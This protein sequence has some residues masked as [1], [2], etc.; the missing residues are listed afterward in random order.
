MPDSA[1]PSDNLSCTRGYPSDETDFGLAMNFILLPWQLL[2]LILVGWT[3]KQQRSIERSS[4]TNVPRA[5][6]V[7]KLCA[8]ARR[9][10]PVG[11]IPCP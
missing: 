10:F 5:R 3:K 2:L 9:R 11:A 6:M 1:Q 8:V 4:C 7:K